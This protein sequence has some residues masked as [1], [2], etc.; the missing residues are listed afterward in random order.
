MKKMLPS[1]AAV[2]ACAF[3][4]AIAQETATPDR[5]SDP[6]PNIQA[7]P[8]TESD[9]HDDKQTKHEAPTDQNEFVTRAAKGGMAE[10]KLA[11]IA[12]EKASDSKIKEFAQ[13]LV[14]D[15]TAANNE[16]KT[17]AESLKIPLPGESTTK[18]DPKCEQLKQKTGA[19]FDKAFLQEMD[20]CHA[21][22]IALYGPGKK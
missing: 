18:E 9:K 21:K 2:T 8:R 13:Q 14:K 3:C 11:Q 16:L 19:E 1:I 5:R 10:V 4:P 17:V 15:H 12:V 22:D 7:P 6:Q 20:H